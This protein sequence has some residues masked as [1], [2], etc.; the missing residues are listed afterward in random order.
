MKCSWSSVI[1]HSDAHD[2][3]VSVNRIL[4]PSWGRARVL[5]GFWSSASLLSY[6]SC[7]GLPRAVNFPAR[8]LARLGRAQTVGLFVFLKELA[9]LSLS[10]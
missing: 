3:V 1:F 8:E 4:P 6:W 7:L 10:I 9:H 5:S 2:L